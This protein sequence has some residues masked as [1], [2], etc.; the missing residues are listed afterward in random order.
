MFD[1][2]L[3]SDRTLKANNVSNIAADKFHSLPKCQGEKK[4]K[5]LKLDASHMFSAQHHRKY[6]AAALLSV[7]CGPEYVIKNIS[8]YP[9]IPQ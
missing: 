7:A 3:Q 5:S 1:Q 8:C 4:L 2:Q 9:Q 6:K